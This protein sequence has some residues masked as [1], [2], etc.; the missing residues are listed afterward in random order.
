MSRWTTPALRSGT[1]KAGHTPAPD[2]LTW[3]EPKVRKRPPV[4][5]GLL[6]RADL[7]VQVKEVC[8]V[9]AGRVLQHA[10]EDARQWR[11][12]PLGGRPH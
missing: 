5:P 2:Y 11:C 7:A 12:T 8:P 9:L 6:T 10:A 4:S 1:L 3:L